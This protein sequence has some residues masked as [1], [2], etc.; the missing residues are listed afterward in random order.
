MN[1]ARTVLLGSLV[2]GGIL[3]ALL[4]LSPRPGRDSNRSQAPLVLFCAAGLKPAIE[5]ALRSYEKAY[6]VRVQ[7]QYG[8]SGTLLG[9]L[10]V[11]PLGDLFLAADGSFL[12]QARSNGLVA[13]VVPLARLTPVIGVARGNPARIQDPDDL[14]RPEVRLV[15]ANP[16]AAAVGRI[17]REQLERR[18]DWSRFASHARAF[19]PTVNDLANDLKLGAADATVIWDATVRQYPELEALATLPFPGVTSEVAIGVLRTSRQPRSALHLAR[20]LGAPEHGLKHF[21]DQGFAVVDGDAWSESP[22]LVFFSGGVNRTAIETSLRQFEEREGV[23]ITRIYNGCGILTAQIRSGQRPDG[24]FACDVSF[25]RTVQ[26]QFLPALEMA[27]TRMV[28]AAP[29]GNPRGFE[30][31]Q[32]LAQPGLKLGL[33]H[34]QQSALGALT[35]QLLR[36]EGWFDSVMS[37]VVVQTPTADLLVN[38]LRAGGLDAVVVYQVNTTTAADRIA[39]VPIDLPGATA[40]QPVAVGRQTRYPHLMER[41]ISFLRST[42]SQRR[43][44]QAGFRWRAPA[45]PEPAR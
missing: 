16:D 8:G 20:Y 41:L 39:V 7:V 37:N 23:R 33:A 27:E 9:S 45:Q 14:L 36:H 32:D 11:A 43:F 3:V 24:Y 25:M 19:K 42:E 13:E 12:D 2:L 29:K 28:I 44:V 21:A 31:L 4:L 30:K 17:T 18:G 38:Q 40:I 35:A 34:E 5:P 15:L 1:T 22:E 10:K 26:D 6:G